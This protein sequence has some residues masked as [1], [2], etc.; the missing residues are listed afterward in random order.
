[1]KEQLTPNEYSTPGRGM[2]TILFA[3][4]LPRLLA[5]RWL[6]LAH[7]TSLKEEYVLFIFALIIV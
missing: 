1:M 7:K 2:K 6:I 4:T 3:S 5:A